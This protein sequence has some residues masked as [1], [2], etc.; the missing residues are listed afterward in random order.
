MHLALDSTAEFKT[1]VGVFLRGHRPAGRPVPGSQLDR[2]S[3]G[4]ADPEVVITAFDQGNLLI[5]VVAD[6]LVCLVRALTPPVLTLASWA[7]LRLILESAS[8]SCWLLDPSVDARTRV[9]RSFANSFKGLD[10]Q[11]GVAKV[12][13]PADLP[14]AEKQLDDLLASADAL[15]FPPLLDRKTGTRR[16]GAGEPMPYSTDLVADV[17]G[18]GPMYKILSAF[19]HGHYWAAVKLS[20]AQVD[21]GTPKDATLVHAME[22][23]HMLGHL[24]YAA[25]WFARPVWYMSRLN[26]YD[27]KALVRIFERHAD[28]VRIAEKERFWRPAV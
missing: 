13:C 2:E 27:L 5:N 1:A 6:Q 25:L 28:Q 15:G 11:K 10:E 8:L 4:F 22:P 9:R 23:F 7:T 3:S 18:Q 16:I 17:L 12:A 26:G 24:V 21:D 14:A 19:V 20:Y